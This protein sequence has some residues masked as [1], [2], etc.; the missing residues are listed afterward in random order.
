MSFD[1]ASL[2]GS[3]SENDL[4]ISKFFASLSLYRDYSDNINELSPFSNSEA[5]NFDD[6]S[7]VDFLSARLSD[8]VDDDS[9]GDN[10]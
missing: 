7:L 6:N 4:D 10:K 3:T 2:S 8:E 1:L 9:F 5:D